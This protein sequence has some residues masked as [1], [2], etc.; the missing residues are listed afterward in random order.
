MKLGAFIAGQPDLPQ[1]S[2]TVR[3]LGHYGVYSEQHLWKRLRAQ[4]VVLSWRSVPAP[5]GGDDAQGRVSE[6]VENRL[7]E[8]G[9]GQMI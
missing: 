9:C 2:G 8:V 6:T 7:R 3:V 4:R 1:R 5:S